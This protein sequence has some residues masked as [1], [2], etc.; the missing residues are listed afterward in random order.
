MLW[1]RVII[2]WAI[3]VLGAFFLSGCNGGS[4][5]AVQNRDILVFAPVLYSQKNMQQAVDALKAHTVFYEVNGIC[6][7]AIFFYTGDSY[8]SVSI[9]QVTKCP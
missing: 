4:S 8:N 2:L 7:A 9:T 6:F 1:F 5:T 3:T